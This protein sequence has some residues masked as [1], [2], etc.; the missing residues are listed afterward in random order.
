MTIGEREGVPF[1]RHDYFVGEWEAVVR[2]LVKGYMSISYFATFLSK[3]FLCYCLFGNQVPESIFIDSFTKYLSP[4]EEE[5]ITRDA[6]RADRVLNW[7]WYLCRR[8]I[9]FFVVASNLHINLFMKLC[10]LLEGVYCSDCLQQKR[11]DQ[12]LLSARISRGRGTSHPYL[13]DVKSSFDL[14]IK[15]GLN[16]ALSLWRPYCLQV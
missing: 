7:A 6:R 8:R 15:P 4:V 10:S 5:L 12:N 1:V 11:P 16:S 13:C 9:F 2:I 3:A 14:F